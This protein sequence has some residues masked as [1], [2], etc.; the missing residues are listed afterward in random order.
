MG[1]AYEN[2]CF[3]S[4]ADAAAA[5]CASHYPQ[6]SVEGGSTVSRSCSAASDGA[7]VVVVATAAGASSA[8]A[9]STTAVTSFASCDPLEPY[10]DIGGMFSAALGCAVLILV[11]V[12][13]FSSLWSND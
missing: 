12:R 4:A 2:T 10:S 6:I 3:D 1:A 9:S 7:S 11:T 5:L 13:S 8:P